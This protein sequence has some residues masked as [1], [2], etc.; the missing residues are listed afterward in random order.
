MLIVRSGWLEPDEVA[1]LARRNLWSAR[2]ESSLHNSYGNFLFGK[3]PELPWRSGSTWRSARTASSGIV[4]MSQEV[5]LACC[6]YKEVRINPRVMPPETGLEMATR[7]GAKAALLADR[8]GSIE[9]GKD[10]DSCCSIP[11]GRNGSR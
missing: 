11:T 6:C 5:Q 9:V 3:L 2:R 10:A 1:I 7:N 8:I 4:D